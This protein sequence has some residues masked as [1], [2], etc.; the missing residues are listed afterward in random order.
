MKL[1]CMK[2]AERTYST[3]MDNWLKG[4]NPFATSDQL[5]KKHQEI[6]ETTTNDLTTHLKGPN[7]EFTMPYTIQLHQVNNSCLSNL[8]FKKL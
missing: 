7:N 4:V 6:Q 2:E 8:L 3:S 1:P 5:S